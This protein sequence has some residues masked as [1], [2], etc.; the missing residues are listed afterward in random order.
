MEHSE[1]TTNATL[2]SKFYQRVIAE[3]GQ[4]KLAIEEAE[5]E[6]QRSQ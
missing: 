3:A 4:Q 5:R 6:R 2:K 1:A